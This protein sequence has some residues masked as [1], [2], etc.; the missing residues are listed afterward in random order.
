[1]AGRPPLPLPNPASEGDEDS[2]AA[3][4][5]A[6]APDTPQL[7][8]LL[9][10]AVHPAPGALDVLLLR[11]ITLVAY[12]TGNAIV[13][14]RGA[15]LA[16]LRVLTQPA[17]S[18]ETGTGGGTG[19]GD[20]PKHGSSPRDD[21]ACSAVSFRE[22]DGAIAAA[23][24]S[25]VI[26][27][28]GWGS[29][30]AK[31]KC[32]YDSKYV[33]ATLNFCGDLVSSI[34]WSRDG[35]RIV[36]V[37]DGVMMWSCAV[38]AS[39][40][41][42][43]T[44][45]AVDPNQKEAFRM[46]LSV[47]C[48]DLPVRRLDLGA[49]SP[50]GHFLAMAPLYARVGWVWK[51]DSRRT[52]ATP[53]TTFGNP[54]AV[55]SRD[56]AVAR[57]TDVYS[58]PPYTV[59]SRTEL[60]FGS[61]GIAAM[62][63]KPR[64]GGKPA[65]MTVDKDGSLRLWAKMA[66]ASS[67]SL[68]PSPSLCPVGDF[69]RLS[70]SP[71]INAESY[72]SYAMP[73]SPLPSGSWMEEIA[74]CPHVENTPRAGASFVQWGGGGGVA[75]DESDAAATTPAHPFFCHGSAPK[76][77]RALHWIVRVAGGDAGAWRARGLDDQPHAEFARLEPGSGR[78]LVGEKEYDSYECTS[79]DDPESSLSCRG[80]DETNGLAWLSDATIAATRAIAPVP[81]TTSS[82][83]RVA[84]VK[85]YA[86]S[87]GER[88]L[89]SPEPPEPPNVAAV[90]LILTKDG[91]SRLARYDLSPTSDS[92][93]V[94]R[95]LIGGGHSTNIVALATV[96]PLIGFDN[97]SLSPFDSSASSWLI[98]SGTGGDSYLWRADAASPTREP[99]I[100]SAVL[101][102]PHTAVSFAPSGL[103]SGRNHES[104]V[105]LFGVDAVSGS[106]HMYK[107]S[108]QHQ[109]RT[110]SSVQTIG[111]VHRLASCSRGRKPVDY[112]SALV[113]VP[114]SV[115]REISGA[116]QSCIILGISPRNKVLCWHVSR[117]TRSEVPHIEPAVLRIIGN[118]LGFV[119]AVDTTVELGTS[120]S[121]VVVGCANACVRI[122]ELLEDVCAADCENAGSDTDPPICH[123]TIWEDTG[124]DGLVQLREI[125]SLN[126]A[127]VP[128]LVA[129]HVAVMGGGERIAMTRS[130][131]RLFL[132]ERNSSIERKWSIA[133]STGGGEV[134]SP[135][136]SEIPRSGGLSFGRDST[137]QIA[138]YYSHLTGLV[139]LY[140]KFQGAKWDLASQIGRTNSQYGPMVHIGMGVLVTGCGRVLEAWDAAPVTGSRGE[141]VSNFAPSQLFLAHLLTG[142]HAWQVIVVLNDLAKQV[143]RFET[144]TCSRDTHVTGG[145][146]VPIPP[147]LQVM[148]ST[149]ES[150]PQLLWDGE[151]SSVPSDVP[152][153]ATSLASILPS[154][155]ASKH[156]ALRNHF[157]ELM[158]LSEAK[159]TLGSGNMLDGSPG[160]ES[161]L[162]S[163]KHVDKL[164][165]LSDRLH[166]VHLLG[167]CDVERVALAALA[168][169]SSHV[170]D[171][172]PS[173][174]ASGAR[175]AIVAAYFLEISAT[176]PV[177]LAAVASA[178]HSTAKDVLLTHFLAAFDVPVKPPA[179]GISAAVPCIPSSSLW[180]ALRRLGCGWWVTSTEDAKILVERIARS[181]FNRTR[182]PDF[183]AFWYIAL[184]RA[185]ML[186]ALYGAKQNKRMALFLNRNF[187][188]AENR[189]AAAKN[190]YAL[191]SKD[192]ILLAAAFFLLAG[193]VGGALNLIR[194][195]MK[196]A[197][198][199][200]LLA[201]VVSD[202]EKVRTTLLSIL[203]S[204]DAQ[205][206]PHLSAI[207][208]WL[209][210]RHE[211]ALE[212]LV[213]P[214]AP[215]PR[216]P[217]FSESDLAYG[218]CLPRVAVV[219]GHVALLAS[220]PVLSRIA[221]A[222]D[223][224]S[225]SRE[226]ASKALY[227]ESSALVALRIG[228]ELVGMDGI[229]VP[230]LDDSGLWNSM[231]NNRLSRKPDYRP[232]R[233]FLMGH[234][235]I[236]AVEVLRERAA[237]TTR[238]VRRGMTDQRVLTML[239]LDLNSLFRGPFKV[240]FIVEIACS[241]A[242]ILS[243]DD[244]I[245]SACALAIGSSIFANKVGSKRSCR[246][247]SDQIEDVVYLAA[248]RCIFR[249]LCAVS[250]LHRP[251]AT[252]AELYDLQVKSQST[253]RLLEDYESTVG[254]SSCRRL[255]GVMIDASLPIGLS[256]SYIRGDWIGL[257]NVLH[258]CEQPLT[259]RY[260]HFVA[261]DLRFESDN[262]HAE[263]RMMI[264]KS[265]TGANALE[266]ISLE[267]LRHISSNPAILGISPRLGHRRRQRL[268][269]SLAL[270][271]NEGVSSFLVSD[272]MSVSDVKS[273]AFGS[274]LDII[275]GHPVLSSAL[276]SAAI[277][278]LAS[279]QA[280]R[281]SEHVTLSGNSLAIVRKDSLRE[282]TNLSR[283]LEVSEALEHVAADALAGWIPLNQLGW[284]MAASS[285]MASEDSVGAFVDLWSTLG[286][287]PEFAPALSEAATVAAAEMAAAAAKQA[288]VREKHNAM[289]S[290]RTG[291]FAQSR[292]K[293]S[294]LGSIAHNAI[295]DTTSA[296]SLF[297][298]YP[299]RFSAGAAGPWSG[300]GRYACLYS[301]QQA[302]F[303]T[304]C[305][306]SS[307]PPAV[308]VATP[309]GIQEIVP[310]SYTAMPAGFRAH[311]FSKHRKVDSRKSE[312]VG[313]R[314]LRKHN[315]NSNTDASRSVDM[316]GSHDLFETA[317]GEGAYVPLDM[318]SK[319]SNGS[320]GSRRARYSSSGR[321]PIWRHQVDSTAL[322]AHPL[323]RRFASGDSHGSLRLW[324]FGDPISLAELRHHHTGRVS[325]LKYSAY[326][327]AIVSA[328][329]SGHL[330]LWKDPD[331]AHRAAAVYGSKGGRDSAVITGYHGHANDVVF[332]DEKFVVAA[333]GEH[334]SPPAAGHSLRVFDT[335]E[336]DS[337]YEPSWSARVHN[338][339]EARC[340][341]LLEDRI[342]IVTG[343]IDGSLSVID[344]R[345]SRNASLG[346]AMQAQV[347]ELAAH[348]DMVTCLA[349]ESPRERALVSGCRNGDIMIWD[350]RTLL[351][352]DFIA[353]A[354]NPTRHFWSGDGI[355]GLV[356]SYGTQAVALT[357]RSLISCGG[358][359]VVK[360]W[361]PGWSTKDLN[362]L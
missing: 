116:S 174:D 105:A 195:R 109:H 135:C 143:E 260:D 89:R 332:L 275:H 355:G 119:S 254:A 27:F 300:R 157:V 293:S 63:W 288:S 107:Y 87:N 14:A 339:G 117:S 267:S 226:R 178:V 114:R 328:H 44:A 77:S 183:V 90:Y 353:A 102:G 271:E 156:G 32:L 360:I 182:D 342:R 33:A 323:R 347:A 179:T 204:E 318:N 66:R 166:H 358:D 28:E 286:C 351:Q 142:G 215:L 93:P 73:T 239:E 280:A 349:M 23:F 311:Y 30:A 31:R 2:D 362:V 69:E 270:V 344:L 60:V 316:G 145:G 305:I 74:R 331:H 8:H 139:E 329:T 56:P 223:T 282:V 42:S 268:A 149:S 247:S 259:R 122:F 169:A 201:R 35:T 298:A 134:S 274:P 348:D 152:K 173:V 171:V 250:P 40:G 285:A 313:S 39:P 248:A 236:F 129:M 289:S 284:T 24:G 199:A 244:E 264:Q 6:L 357:D 26:I 94:C 336:P 231:S 160:N 287:L 292:A 131:G 269:P 168:R 120:V 341:A 188:E 301:E 220:R 125:A 240:D 19:G 315:E 196:D 345:M 255:V 241:A 261:H 80:T 197:Q 354:H 113:T 207:V 49:L 279:H 15:D 29:R 184:G 219:L 187:E 95:A 333:V 304:L 96:P 224:L 104:I 262:E 209:L 58:A 148:L 97:Q 12:S 206:D 265:V 175:Y 340:I 272:E 150:T 176:V 327:N 162:D 36:A 78:A 138:L 192:R 228:L 263:E 5:A 249:S 153:T 222:Q 124:E 100:L 53:Q 7:R 334:S 121:L 25:R 299:V 294:S 235:G 130:D 164:T 205:H 13:V 320:S 51:I 337:T 352:L 191:I 229:S 110:C 154:A 11:S 291:G 21:D 310:S 16:A 325:S 118:P 133:F 193:D 99:L 34:A 20:R 276:G 52:I 321:D 312:N 319:S 246:V 297:G 350:S 256:L 48:L 234:L 273:S 307:D 155:T 144:L 163:G 72:S 85:S 253:I 198:L 281:A 91:T 1:M 335:R 200:V 79:S 111:V 64:G 147:A 238:A 76:P 221:Y 303:R 47:P 212:T 359:G 277:S 61:S 245:D 106:L 167:L 71:N 81:F 136:S 217:T 172:I 227:V 10:P 216:S 302:L 43:S 202:E 46:V 57:T 278:Y 283:L 230:A 251:N 98:S 295:F 62:Q 37:G 324:D 218:A 54:S 211:E 84:L 159:A 101:P 314:R 103:I 237:V 88:R 140:R 59:S 290:R 38:D 141:V 190:A 161:T 203:D 41:S 128:D 9:A 68:Q 123:D 361:G 177:P 65:L 233:R 137:G 210:N 213:R 82:T 296:D 151:Q 3:L 214:V 258:A 83:Q 330:S 75:D 127:V 322:A 17:S 115:R 165:K 185:R 343:G 22:C 146:M 317:F 18:T 309:K 338:G 4:L 108:L 242:A 55:S 158:A 92:T 132:W 243:R 257:R 346:G 194:S 126:G 181:E 180:D 189:T 232:Q 70:A 308:I 252:F 112:V 45:G 356:G 326:G 170:R 208:L 67:P 50:D 86:I 225:V 266:S 306:S 186:S